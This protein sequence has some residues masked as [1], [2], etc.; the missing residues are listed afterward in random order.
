MF[1][2]MTTKNVLRIT[3]SNT[4]LIWKIFLYTAICLLA[5]TG[6]AV[7]AAWPL[8]SSLNADGFFTAIWNYLNTNASNANIGDVLANT[9]GLMDSLMTILSNHTADLLWLLGVVFFV[10]FIVGAIFLGQ[11]GL[12][13][14]QCIYG[15]MAS[16][17]KLSFVGSLLAN[18]GKSMKLRLVKFITLLPLDI[19]IGAALF[20]SLDLFSLGGIWPHIAPSVII[21]GASMLIAIRQALFCCWIPCMTVKNFGVFKALKEGVK[22]SCVKFGRVL[23]SSFVLVLIVFVLNYAFMFFTAGVALILTIPISLM[24]M[25]VFGFV[26]Y[27]QN[28]GL[29]F[30][31]DNGTII[32]PN[33]I[34]SNDELSKIKNIV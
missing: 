22:S 13:A 18:I 33:K 2:V 25:H 4:R 9:G 17:S 19:L 14:G 32:T 29:K 26:V 10:Y 27:F 1:L 24:M 6:I 8:V 5:L 31:V 7:A 3:I 15:Y 11:Q 12:A 34:E 21:L 16:N 30:Y 20:F 28:N 23:L